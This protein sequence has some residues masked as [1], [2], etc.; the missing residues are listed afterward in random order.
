MLETLT[1]PIKIEVYTGGNSTVMSSEIEYAL[2]DDIIAKS[3]TSFSDLDFA[4][5][6]QAFLENFTPTSRVP[7]GLEVFVPVH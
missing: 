1:R 5:H 3:Q 7:H 6:P 4:Y 2:F